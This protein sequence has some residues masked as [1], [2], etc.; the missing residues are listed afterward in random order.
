MPDRERSEVIQARV[1]RGAF[2]PELA[3]IVDAAGV[4]AGGAGFIDDWGVTVRGRADP[5][6]ER[7]TTVTSYSPGTNPP[8][9]SST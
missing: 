6:A 4:F 1:A 3:G 5:N 2:G 9:R 8:V 7:K